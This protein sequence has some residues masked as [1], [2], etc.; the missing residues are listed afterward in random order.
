MTFAPWLRQHLINTGRWNIDGI[1]RAARARTC[2][3]CPQ[4]LLAGLDDPRCAGPATVDPTPLSPLGEALALIDGRTTYT[5]TRRGNHLEL[6]HRNQWTI[7]AHPAGTQPG[8]DIV[9]EHRCST[10]EPSPPLILASSIR[11]PTHQE[12]TNG[13]PPY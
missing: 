13:Q 2:T 8:V 11:P 4:I 3:H 10:P 7:T 6:D 5:L 9:A 1:N 12:R